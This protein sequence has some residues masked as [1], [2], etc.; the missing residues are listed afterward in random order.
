[1][2]EIPFPILFRTKLIEKKISKKDLRG[3]FGDLMTI[4]EANVQSSCLN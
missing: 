4:H 1:M 2:G 3:L